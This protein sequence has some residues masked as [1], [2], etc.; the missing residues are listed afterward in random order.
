MTNVC[1]RKNDLKNNVTNF[2][3]NFRRKYLK[4]ENFNVIN[5]SSFKE[6]KICLMYV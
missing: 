1:L 5:L 2:A 6:N 3:T 4:N